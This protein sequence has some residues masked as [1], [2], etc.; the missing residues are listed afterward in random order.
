MEI[1]LNGIVPCCFTPSPT[2]GASNLVVQSSVDN[3]DDITKFRNKEFAPIPQGH[4]TDT[5]FENAASK[6]DI[7]FQALGLLT[8]NS[9]DQK[10][11]KFFHRRLQLKIS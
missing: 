7:A 1:E 5:E 2:V 8:E 4:L 3:V 10:Q 6:V 9:N 11:D